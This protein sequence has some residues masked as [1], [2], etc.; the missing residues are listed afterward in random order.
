MESHCRVIT[1]PLFPSDVSELPSNQS[2]AELL[3]QD[4]EGIKVAPVGHLPNPSQ[5]SY[6]PFLRL[7]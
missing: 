4:K 5:D 3:G 1:G 2:G 7:Y 6:I